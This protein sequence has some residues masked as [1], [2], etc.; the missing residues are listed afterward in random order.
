MLTRAFNFNIC[1]FFPT[2]HFNQKKVMLSLNV[3]ETDLSSLIATI[4]SPSSIE[5][6][7]ILKCLANRHL[8]ISFIPREIGEHL[9]NVYRHGQHI[10]NSPFNMYVGEGEIGNAGNVK[11]SGKGLV[12]GM[13]N[14]INEF[15][16]DTKDAGKYKYRSE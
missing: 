16:V 4:R 3:T 14:E 15:F 11:V 6:P 1:S 8:G 12:E 13:A 7:C 2:E 5:E 9:L 10:P